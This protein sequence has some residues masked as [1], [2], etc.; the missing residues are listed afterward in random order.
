MF[1]PVGLAQY[2]PSVKGNTLLMDVLPCPTARS[3]VDSCAAAIFR[4]TGRNYGKEGNRKFV[5]A[6]PISHAYIWIRLEVSDE[7]CI[8]V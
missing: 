1:T 4:R 3:V 8:C 6:S 2:L 7:S 5:S